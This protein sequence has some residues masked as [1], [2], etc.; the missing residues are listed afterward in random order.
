MDKVDVGGL[1]QMAFSHLQNADQIAGWVA[2]GIIAVTFILVQRLRT[3][4]I[5][6]FPL[7]G[8]DYY[9]SRRKRAEAFI[10]TPNDVYRRA[11]KTFKDQIYRLTTPDS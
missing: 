6:N 1:N 11:Y 9:G 4:N 10:H 3:P 8:K 7:F 2:A 5:S